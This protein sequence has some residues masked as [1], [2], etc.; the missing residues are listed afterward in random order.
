MFGYNSGFVVLPCELMYFVLMCCEILRSISSAS[1]PLTIF[2]SCRAEV[3]ICDERKNCVFFPCDEY[4]LGF[5]T[6]VFAI[7]LLN[8]FVPQLFVARL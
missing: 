6:Y 5:T 3:P 4:D 7:A 8:V 1:L 2:D